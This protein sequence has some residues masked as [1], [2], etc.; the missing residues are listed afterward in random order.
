MQEE[1]L[2]KIEEYKLKIKLMGIF[3]DFLININKKLEL[4]DLAEYIT[5]FI[6]ASFNIKFCSLII[7]NERFSNSKINDKKLLESEKIIVKEALKTKIIILVKST[8]N[9]TLLHDLKN[10]IDL[11]LLCIPIIYENKIIAFVNIYDDL[12]KIDKENSRLLNYFLN[13]ASPAI[14]NSIEHDITKIKSNT[15]SLTN[16]YNRRYFNEILDEEAKNFN[17]F[18]SLIMLDIDYFKNYNDKNG[19]QAGDYLLKEISLIFK[20][21]LRNKDVVARYGG[22]EFIILLPEADSNNALQ[23]SERLRKS[24]ENYNFRFKEN[25]P[26]NKV[27]ISLGLT[28]II[29]KCIDTNDIIKEA[30]KNLYKSKK[31]GRNKITSSIII[32]KNLHVN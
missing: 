21:S 1:L 32:D 12:E 25:Q 23:I 8:L 9:D 13:K 5:N 10:D 6:K 31:S 30:D 14:F 2:K 20:N 28:T 3:E 26:D 15:D 17:K 7:N 29:T 22:E 19:H 18:L 11:S 24:V 16:L 27:T 4:K